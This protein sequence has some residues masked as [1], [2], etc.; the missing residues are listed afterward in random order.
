MK[1]K[2]IISFLVLSMVLCACSPTPSSEPSMGSSS[3]SEPSSEPSSET[4]SELVVEILTQELTLP[5]GGFGYVETVTDGVT[6]ISDNPNIVT[7]DETG[8]VSAIG[9]G[10]T[11]IVVEKEGYIS[12]SCFIEVVEAFSMNGTYHSSLGTLEVNG[13]V[14][15]LGDTYFSASNCLFNDEGYV[16]YELEHN[17]ELFY[18]SLVGEDKF[19]L[20]LSSFNETKQDFEVVGSFM[21]TIKEFSGYYTYDGSGDP[22]NTVLSIGDEYDA[23]KDVY[24]VGT[25][26]YSSYYGS[27]DV[28]YVKS[29]KT[30][31]DGQFVTAIEL[32]DY[33][34]DYS[35][36]VYVIKEEENTYC[37]YNFEYDYADW[38]LDVTYL[39]ATFVGNNGDTTLMYVDAANDTIYDYNIDASYTYTVGYDNI[40]GQ[41]ITINNEGNEYRI[42]P[43]P[44]GFSVNGPANFYYEYAIKDLANI[45]DDVYENNNI[46]FTFTFSYDTFDY[47]AKVNDVEVDYSLTIYDSRAS[48]KVTLEGVDHFFTSY[49]EGIAMIHA[50]EGKEEFLTNKEAFIEAF[51][52]EFTSIYFGER[53]DAK[54]DSS[55][56]LLINNN[57]YPLDLVYNPKVGYPYL[58]DK[59]QLFTFEIFDSSSAIYSLCFNESYVYFIA[60]DRFESIKGEYTD[61][62]E[63]SLTISDTIV[64]IKGNASGYNLTA[65]YLKESF[66]YI[67]GFVAASEYYI[68]EQDMIT[69]VAKETGTEDWI[70]VETFIKTELALTLIGKYCFNGSLG[71]ETFELKEDGT[72]FADALENG[73]LV[74]RQYDYHLYVM[75]YNNVLTPVIG[76]IVD[77]GTNSMVVFLYYEGFSVTVFGS[78]Y[79][80][81]ELFNVNGVYVNSDKTSVLSIIDNN[82]YLD[83]IKGT[84]SEISSSGNA[85]F[86]TFDING[87]SHSVSIANGVLTFS[88]GDLTGEIYTQ[89]EFDVGALVGTHTA[90]GSTVT[91]SANINP[92]TQVQNGYLFADGFGNVTEYTFVIYN[93]QLAVKVVIGMI[94]Y[95]FVISEEVVVLFV[96]DTLPPPPPPLPVAA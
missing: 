87:S 31:V 61:K 30:V 7:V 60:S 21:P 85:T 10:T 25:Y 70:T 32:F 79:V 67:L 44:F 1:L 26:F 6:F 78:K 34:D 47:I 20:E 3:S 65:I 22:Y 51:E 71:V 49:K 77:N 17:D 69:H 46:K 59:N 36:G 18:L 93:G 33:A 16:T 94:N 73:Q 39:N 55:F 28:Y 19:T 40:D 76:F 38:Y 58:Q 37:L 23:Y 82:V 95:Y 29:F 43:N 45:E 80:R 92:M 63:T 68:V 53:I 50:S 57:E 42:H 91:V 54:I 62:I 35:Y 52:F 15:K 56:N 2:K 84:V 24:F 89:T 12:T 96:E 8:K 81:Q 14:V 74:N 66:S 27:L 11:Q 90:N 64:N 41:I 48:Y 4:S 5:K 13:E 9:V 75:E 83:G 72:F 88:W 86:I